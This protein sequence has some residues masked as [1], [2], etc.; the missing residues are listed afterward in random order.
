MQVARILEP[1]P[2]TVLGK[3]RQI[4]R[5]L[6]LE[7]RQSKREILELYLTFAPMGG[8]LEGVEAASRAYLGKPAKRLTESGAALLAVMPQA[9]SRL[10]PDRYPERARLAR[11]KVLGRMQP[12]WGTAAVADARQEPVIAQTVREPLLAPLF[13]ERLR[14][15]RPRETRIDTTLDANVQNTVEQLLASRL[16]V[17]PPHVSMAALV[18]DNATLEVRAYAGSA[19]FSDDERF[20][21]VDMVQIGRVAANRSLTQKFPEAGR[22]QITVMDD[23]GRYDRVEISVR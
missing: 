1:T 20:A 23:A 14:R 17:L 6:Q 11:D 10:R 5:A 8:V 3:L 7:L 2:H 16:A 9:P 13:A 22:Y 12:V 21:H 4:A 19:D 18:V 15:L